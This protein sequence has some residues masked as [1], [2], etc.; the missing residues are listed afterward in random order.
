MTRRCGRAERQFALI[1]LDVKMPGLD[2]LE[3]ASLIR[4]RRKSAHTPIIL[5]TA[6]YGD[7]LRMTKAYSLGAVDYIASPVVPEILRAKV[8]VFVELFLLADQ[9]KR[10]AQE[11]IALVEEK[12]AREAAGTRVAPARFPRRGERHPRELAR[13]RG[14]VA[15]VVAPHRAAFRRRLHRVACARRSTDRAA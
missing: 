5:V 7:E 11:R 4:S 3:T 10:Q 14:D 2:G 6:D 9:A 12:A 1:L 8:K 15:R 13:P